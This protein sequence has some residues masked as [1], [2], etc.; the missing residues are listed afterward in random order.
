MGSYWSK[1]D[2]EHQRL[3]TIIRALEYRISCVEHSPKAK[4]KELLPKL[5]N[6]LSTAIKNHEFKPRKIRSATD[7]PRGPCGKGLFN[8]LS[9]AIKHR[10]NKVRPEETPD[11]YNWEE[12]V[13]NALPV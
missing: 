12:Q 4:P 8:E 9:N 6:P 10:R 3:M 1:N 13:I 7:K 11:V 5:A 2:D